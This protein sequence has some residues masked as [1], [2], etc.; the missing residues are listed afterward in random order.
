LENEKNKYIV[1]DDPCV[2]TTAKQ[3]S[4][5]PDQ[6]AKI[7]EA[8]QEERERVITMPDLDTMEKALKDQ[9]TVLLDAEFESFLMQN[10]DFWI[11]V[12]DMFKARVDGAK[13]LSNKK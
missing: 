10:K 1:M 9:K 11:G 8:C 5:T 4:S 13:A 2:Y 3:I 6:K 12:D 7:M